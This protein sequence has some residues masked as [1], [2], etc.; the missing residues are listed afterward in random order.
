VHAHLVL[1]RPRPDLGAEDRQGLAD[2]LTAALQR[3]PSVRR[4]RVGRRV[5]HGRPY[6]QLMRSD[7]THLAILEFDDLAG[8]EAY[9]EHPVHDQLGTRFFAAFEDALMYDYDMTDGEE[10]IRALAL[11]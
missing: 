11:A 9:L 8:L 7:Y 6:E 2:A 1:F 5:T 10:G 3:I 4:V